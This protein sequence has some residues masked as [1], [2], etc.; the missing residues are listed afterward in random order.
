LKSEFLDVATGE[1]APDIIKARVGDVFVKITN[2]E[3]WM[4]AG[5]DNGLQNPPHP[6]K[7]LIPETDRLAFGVKRTYGVDLSNEF[8]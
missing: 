1:L 8:A 6:Q 2:V 5:I 3:M 4:G 7:R